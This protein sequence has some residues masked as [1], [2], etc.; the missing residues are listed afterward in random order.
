MDHKTYFTKLVESRPKK[1][2][3][4]MLADFLETVAFSI[5][6]DRVRYKFFQSCHYLRRHE[7]EG[8]DWY[9]CSKCKLRIDAQLK[10]GDKGVSCSISN[11]DAGPSN[12]TGRGKLEASPLTLVTKK[13]VDSIDET[14]KNGPMPKILSEDLVPVFLQEISKAPQPI[15]HVLGSTLA[16]IKRICVNHRSRHSPGCFPR[17]KSEINFRAEIKRN[18]FLSKPLQTN[19]Q[20]PP[21]TFIEPNPHRKRS[22]F[23][24]RLIKKDSRPN[25]IPL[26]IIDANFQFSDPRIEKMNALMKKSRDPRKWKR[27]SST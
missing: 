25:T 9:R 4:N 26:R 27:S 16:Y 14:T 18:G 13:I 23:G 24:H 17:V 8:S 10:S 7:S 21:A 2:K 11:T 3:L 19:S 6:R 5:F 12:T 15:A 20:A 22:F 1:D